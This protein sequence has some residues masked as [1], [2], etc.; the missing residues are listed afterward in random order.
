MTS[1]IENLE[2]EIAATT[3]V[4]TPD[5]AVDGTAAEEKNAEIPE[6]AAT[7]AETEVEETPP[8][9]EAEAA[10]EDAAGRKGYGPVQ[11]KK[12]SLSLEEI[13]KRRLM[14]K[15]RAKKYV[16][17]GNDVFYQEVESKYASEREQIDP[18]IE[19][20]I[21]AFQH[22]TYLTARVSGIRFDPDYGHCVLC[23]Y[24]DE[25]AGETVYQVLIP[26][27]MFTDVTEEE[28]ERLRIAPRVYL[29]RRIGSMID[30]VPEEYF[31]RDDTFIFVGNRLKA[32]F[33][34][35]YEHW[36]ATNRGDNSLRFNVGSHV[37]ARIVGKYPRMGI[38]VELFGV[39]TN[40]RL[41]EL[42]WTRIDPD[43]STFRPEVGDNIV[44]CI[45]KLKRNPQTREVS[46][47][48]SVKKTMPDPRLAAFERLSVGDEMHGVVTNILFRE[49]DI[50][51]SRVF[52]RLDGGGEAMCARIDHYNIRE[53]NRVALRIGNK[54]VSDS[55][56]PRLEAFITHVF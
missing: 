47:E 5:I 42:S 43:L 23:F 17:D 41:D 33:L 10:Q 25:Q 46:F 27:E 39:E 20:L 26:W 22:T 55:G 52:I 14:R 9:S 3:A 50:N 38:R 15:T 56:E 54:Y 1:S 48:A 13:E 21:Y 18:A 51:K 32:M 28:L 49:D 36:F 2:K 8:E 19:R 45:T 24:G 12:S 29:S 11:T 37:E 35:C 53:G 16:E 31:K 6:Q 30:F 44:V 40:I 4:E 7:E 34:T